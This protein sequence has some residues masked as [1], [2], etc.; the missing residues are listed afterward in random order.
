M[1][2]REEW[3]ILLKHAEEEL[4]LTKGYKFL[5]VPWK[6]L[7]SASVTFLS[8][9]PGR[10]PDAA[11]MRVVADERGNSYEVEQYTTKS[12]ITAQ[13]MRFAEFLG[14]A[15][16]DILTGVVAPFRS[17]GWAELSSTQKRRSLEL[18]YAFWSEPLRHPDLKV[19]TVCSEEA[20]SMAVDITDASLDEVL[21]SGWGTIKIRRYRTPQGQLIV[22]LPHLSRF[23]L[24]G[25]P[26]SEGPLRKAF[27]LNSAIVS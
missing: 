16:N 10:A 20:A 11:D 17:D 25:R 22:H 2:T 6:T 21:D 13:F 18:G 7:N 24:F 12:N 15:P 26:E 23:R 4:G 5:Y 27:E 9:N 3:D 8:L 1:K 19:I 14:C